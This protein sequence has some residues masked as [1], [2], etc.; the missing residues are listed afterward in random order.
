LAV[1]FFEPGHLV[2][3]WLPLFHDMGLIGHALLPLLWDVPSVL[4]EP[5]SFARR[6]ESWFEALAGFGATVSTA[7]NFAFRLS[8]AR[9][10]PAFLAELDLSRVRILMCGGEPILWDTLTD[11]RDRFA[12]TGLA[13][14]ALRPVYGLA[15]AT[16]TVS[17]TPKTPF[18]RV[19]EICRETFASTGRAVPR[20]AE[21]GAPEQSL[22]VVSVG[23]P[24]D[25]TSVKIADPSDEALPERVEGHVWVRGPSLMASY[26]DDAKLSARTLREGWLET[27]DR[28]YLADGELFITGRD[29]ELIIKGGRNL[30]PQ[31]IEAIAG[32][33][34]G[35]RA[36]RVAAFGVLDE[37]KGTDRLVVICE[38]RRSSKAERSLLERQVIG[39]VGAA[40]G[41]QPDEVAVR[42]PGT[43]SKTS[44][45]KMQRLL[46]REKYLEGTLGDGAKR[47]WL[48]AQLWVERMRRLTG[49]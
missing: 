8:A 29:K 36:G 6:P 32:S 47:R 46:A 31:E 37:A 26:F 34:P 7:P 21:S 43:L 24:I 9:A 2:C 30:Y 41:V 25:E 10:N 48:M 5:Q 14:S 49:G 16:L 12:T 38:S 3:S 17:V 33:V 28:G 11:F 15:E 13:P 20:K 19:D 27:G 42:G 22:T 35:I 18:P 4:L 45:G 1:V 23:F 44:S 40:L 39:E